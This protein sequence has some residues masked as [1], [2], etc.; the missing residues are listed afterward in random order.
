MIS[1]RTNTHNGVD[2]HMIE[3]DQLIEGALGF[4]TNKYVLNGRP[5]IVTMKNSYKYGNQVQ[6]NLFNSAGNTK[7]VERVNYAG[8]YDRIEIFFDKE[9]FTNMC[10]EFL[11]NSEAEVT[12]GV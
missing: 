11:K 5:S 1:I 9:E 3:S 4:D 10:K 8:N 6:I 12:I 7:Q 2:Y